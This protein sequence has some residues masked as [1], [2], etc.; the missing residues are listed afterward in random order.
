MAMLAVAAVPVPLVAGLVGPA[1]IIIYALVIS[2]LV[3]LAGFRLHGNQSTDQT[4]CQPHRTHP[5]PPMSSRQYVLCQW[6]LWQNP[7]CKHIGG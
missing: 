6:I 4:A 7:L 1:A 2:L 3:W 5:R